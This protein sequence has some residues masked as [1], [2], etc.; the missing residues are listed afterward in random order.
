MGVYH[1]RESI[2]PKSNHFLSQSKKRRKETILEDML[3]EDLEI[4]IEESK[5]N[6]NGY[7][8]NHL[9]K[10]EYKIGKGLSKYKKF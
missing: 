5:D 1:H 3:K 4:T 10:I 8:L 9:E 7:L 6:F 2:F